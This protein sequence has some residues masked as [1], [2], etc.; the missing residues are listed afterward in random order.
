LRRGK[1]DY[2]DLGMRRNRCGS[3]RTFTYNATL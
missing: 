3:E 1:L 2:Y